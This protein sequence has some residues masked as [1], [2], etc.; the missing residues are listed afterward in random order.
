[1]IS[2]I[3][4]L[5]D[6]QIFHKLIIPI[7]SLLVFCH[8]NNLH[9]LNNYSYKSQEITTIQYFHMCLSDETRVHGAKYFIIISTHKRSITQKI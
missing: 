4:S 9:S 8:E 2:F 1:M 5:Y 7:D 6:G 3:Q